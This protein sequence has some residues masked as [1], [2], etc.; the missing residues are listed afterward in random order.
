MTSDFTSEITVLVHELFCRK[1][2]VHA[3]CR[4]VFV[5]FGILMEGGSLWMVFGGVGVLVRLECESRC[6][7]GW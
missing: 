5:I 4:G 1:L 7:T 2:S 3:G 6:E